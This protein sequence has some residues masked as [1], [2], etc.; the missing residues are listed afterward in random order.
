M[1]QDK[2]SPYSFKTASDAPATWTVTAVAVAKNFS[3]VTS[4]P[5][6]ITVVQDVAPTVAITSPADGT[7]YNSK[8]TVVIDASASSEYSTISEVDFY[9]GSTLLKADK[10]APYAY[11][12]SKPAAGTYSLTAVAIDAQGLSTTSAPVSITVNP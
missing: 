11:N 8:P 7:V 5:V 10:S 1:D 12:W 9:Q 2:S 6:T 4:A 3:T